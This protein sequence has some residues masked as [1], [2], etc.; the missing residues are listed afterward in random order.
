MKKSRKIV[1]CLFLAIILAVQ[2]IS[3][4]NIFADTSDSI[5][6]NIG[7]KNV[8]IGDESNVSISFNQKYEENTITLT[9]ICSDVTQ[10]TTLT[11]NQSTNSYEGIIQYKVESEATDVWSI[12]QIKIGNK[13][14]NKK[15]LQDLGLNLSDY[16][17]N[18]IA[19]QANVESILKKYVNRRSAIYT[20]SLNSGYTVLLD[21]GHGGVSGSGYNWGGTLPVNDT[22]WEKDY[23]L[24]TTLA[25]AEYLRNLGINVVLTRD[26]DVYVPLADRSAL[27]NTLNPDLALSIHYNGYDAEYN[28]TSAYYKYADRNGGTGKVLAEN[29]VNS[30]VDG[31]NFKK[32]GAK[33]WTDIENGVLVDH[34]HMIRVPNGNVSLIE[35]CYLSNES[36]QAKVNTKEKRKLMGIQ[37]AKGV[38][39]TLNYMIKNGEKPNNGSLITDPYPEPEP[40]P[41]PKPEPEVIKS[42]ITMATLNVRKGPS[43][44]YA[45]LGYLTKD[46]KVQIVEVDKTTGWY[47]IKYKDDYGYVSNK[48]VKLDDTTGGTSG[49]QT[50]GATGGQTQNPTVI[51]TGKTTATLNV[52]KGPSTSYASL[53]Y[54]AKDTKVQIVEIDK[55]TGWY[56]IKYNDSYGYVSNKYVKL[57]DTTGGTS[58]GQTGGTTSGETQNPTVIKTGKTTATLNVRKGPSTSY[59][60]LGYLIKGTKIEIVGVDKTTGWYK[61]KYKTGYAYVSN[62]YVTLNK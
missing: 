39:K 5:Q 14:L 3:I 28:G 13:T 11:Y 21:A 32:E 31:F 24:D 43:T 42:G 35:C 8:S 12:K 40:K 30:I 10:D 19:N 37:I 4:S 15:Y 20:R 53:G 23:N 26:S 45:S 50:G 52:R 25:A 9:Q 58:G 55:A 54:L 17:V 33:Y 56:K 6:I 7:S 1:L 57:D 61:I 34:L 49:G 16:N 59:A 41:E 18:L 62:K 47:K 36:D 29:V 38:V 2:N 48:Y 51:K 60:S 22:L 27:I 44:S 46:T